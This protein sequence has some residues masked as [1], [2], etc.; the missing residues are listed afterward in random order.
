MNKLITSILSAGVVTLVSASCV[1]AQDEERMAKFVPTELFACD[2]KEGK[3]P[4][5]L[6]AVVDQWNAYMDEREADSYRA[7]TLTRQFFTPEQD[8]DVLWLGASTDGNASGQGRD[9][10]HATGGATMAAFASVVDCK[11]HVGF[12][13]R[14]IKFPP[15][16]DARP[17]EKA[18]VTFTDCTI[19]EGATYDTQLEG[20]LAWGKTLEDDGSV[21]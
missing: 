20:L 15:N 4:G 13:S 3:G 18:V 11:A 16:R 7:L 21:A 6:D 17:P 8:F 5:D 9:D 19:E 10:Y 1:N 12:A 2:Y 14:A